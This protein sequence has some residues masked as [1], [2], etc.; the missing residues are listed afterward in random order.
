MSVTLR[1]STTARRLAWALRSALRRRFE[2]DRPAS[3]DVKDGLIAWGQ[4]FLPRHL[5]Q[6]PSP[7]HRWLADRLD[8]SRTRRGAKLN[9][10]G[11][12]GSAK[13]TIA[14]LA[15]VLRGAVEGDEPYT[16]IVSDTKAQAQ[17][18][19]E[20]VKAELLDNHRLAEAYPRA[21]GK[22]PRWTA[23]AIELRNGSMIE[24]YGSGQRLRGR[25]R[26]E[27]RPTLIVC[28]DLQND[29]HIE[30]APLREASSAWFHGALMK[31]G[32]SGA[33]VVNVATALHRDAL[34][35]RLADA[36]GWESRTFQSIVRWP[37]NDT[38]WR[39][40][41]KLYADPE[42]DDSATTAAAFYEE[43][44]LAM[45][46]GAEVLW[47]EQE[48]LYDLMRTRVESG[49]AAF[50]REKQSSPIDPSRCEWPES[51]FEDSVWF[52][53][54]PERMTLRTL[55]LDPS[56]GGDARHGDYSAYVLLGVDESGVL[57]VEAD[58][59][60]RPTP[61]MVADGVRLVERFLPDAFGVE[62]NQWQQLLA[63]E[64]LAEFRHRGSLGAAPSELHNH[65]S[66]PIRIRRLGPYLSQRRFRFKRNSPG[67]ELLVNQLRDF[68]LA[69]HDDGPDALEM[70]LRLA[71]EVWRSRSDSD[72]APPE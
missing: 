46:A 60:R 41:E 65:V 8:A 14:T 66:K 32:A 52:D 21:V 40:W 58:L 15:H 62:A 19:L 6:P 34:A 68:P 67:T 45:N 53:E 48:D 7:L 31:A 9:L 44:R 20:N 30:S 28:D 13:S 23:T 3:H 29:R 27:N 17:T 22:G 12:R 24:A 10:I 35:I 59:A 11:P 57:H 25:R 69:S 43:N 54:W 70:A 37:D 5:S 33:N 38:L 18:H 56:K 42:S 4:E 64:F 1:S 51:Y 47:P 63:G 36:P 39:R 50:E 49:S 26:R 72:V 71:E 55:A 2:S 61:Q 16:W